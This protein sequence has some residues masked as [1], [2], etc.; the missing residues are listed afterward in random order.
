MDLVT[1][2]LA[3]AIHPLLDKLFAFFGHS[4]GA[5]I[6]FELT[7]E[8]RRRA[9]TAKLPIV[10]GQNAPDI[11]PEVIRHDLSRLVFLHDIEVAVVSQV[12]CELEMFSW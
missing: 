3:D 5:A 9:V 7:W 4:T 10:S 6:C 1:T 2:A 11:K 12:N 8:L